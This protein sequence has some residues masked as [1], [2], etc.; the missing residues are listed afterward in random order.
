MVEE[1]GDDDETDKLGH[2]TTGEKASTAGKGGEDMSASR[3]IIIAAA[4]GIVDVLG[5]GM[6]MLCPEMWVLDLGDESLP[7]NQD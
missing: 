5:L 3:A 2:M 4:D 6:V 1:D 7:S